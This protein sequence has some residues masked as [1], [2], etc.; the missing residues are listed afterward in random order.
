M[1]KRR[2]FSIDVVGQDAFL[3]MPTDSRELYFQLGMYAD[4][5]GFV[6]PRKVM[7]VV[8]AGSVSIKLLISKGYV[9]PFESGVVVV[10]HWKQNNYIQ[11]DRFA[12]TTFKQERAIWKDICTQD[13]YKV[14]TQGGRE[15]REESKN[16][17]SSLKELGEHL[18]AKGIVK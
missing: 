11:A 10:T 5:E 6:S 4:D 3:D 13:V 1:A 14:D 18:K 2:M 12:P 7:R 8:G 16:K 17:G 9:Y 15:V